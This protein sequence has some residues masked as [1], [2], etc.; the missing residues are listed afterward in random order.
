MM[1]HIPSMCMAILVVAFALILPAPAGA[2][3]LEA[4]LGV[5]ITIDIAPFGIEYVEPELA[6]ALWLGAE[7]TFRPGLLLEA[8]AWDGRGDLSA[9]LCGRL[10]IERAAFIGGFGMLAFFEGG[11]SLMPTV[12]GGLRI[13]LGTFALIFPLVSVRFKPTDSDTEIRA[14]ATVSF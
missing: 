3:D 10:D 1:K 12:L 2:G 5:G 8:S 6:A 7:R 4:D 9:S 13:E 11:Q 14:L